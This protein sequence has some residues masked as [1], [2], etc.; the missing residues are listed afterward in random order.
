MWEAGGEGCA[1]CMQLPSMLLARGA[2]PR[3]LRHSL[4][5]SPFSPSYRKVAA[6]KM[7]GTHAPLT[8]GPPAWVECTASVLNPG[9]CGWPGTPHGV[10][11]HATQLP[12]AALMVGRLRV[13][14]RGA[15]H[16][17]AGAAA[18][19]RSVRKRE[20]AARRSR[21]ARRPRLLAS[22]ACHA[23]M[24]ASGPAASCLRTYTPPGHTRS[25]N[26]LMEAGNCSAARS[27]NQS[28][29][30]CPCIALR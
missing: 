10:S 30:R 7:G 18:G 13:V 11:P 14:R 26:S 12:L 21:T 27:L 23:C 4:Y 15:A 28:L 29:N 8:R 22:R 19:S 2:Q 17:V 9:A 20:A 24:H 6:W 3:M 5:R 16:D 1:G 25:A